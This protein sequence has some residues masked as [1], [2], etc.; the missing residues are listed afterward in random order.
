MDLDQVKQHGI[1]WSI[2]T[3]VGAGPSTSLLAE[4]ACFLMVHHGR[5]GTNA[6]EALWAVT[7]GPAQLLKLD[8]RLGRFAQG[9]DCSYIEVDSFNSRDSTSRGIP[10]VVDSRLFIETCLLGMSTLEPP[11]NLRE[12]LDRLAAEGLEDQPCLQILQTHLAENVNR[13]EGRVRRVVLK[14]TEVWAK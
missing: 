2:S 13:L 12:I 9:M 4:M 1:P 3:D 8:H 6:A 14:G 10:R 11:G 5:H 7:L